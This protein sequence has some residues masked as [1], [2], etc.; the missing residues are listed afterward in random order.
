MLLDVALVHEL[1]LKVLVRLVD[2]LLNVLVRLVDALLM[3]S[4]GVASSGIHY[5]TISALQRAEASLLA[6]FY[7]TEILMGV[8]CGYVFFGDVPD[9][10]SV[11]GMAGVILVGLYLSRQGEAAAAAV[12]AP[13]KANTR[14]RNSA[15]V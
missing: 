10:W 12:P 13:P 3:A 6:P 14:T 9:G 8:V 5:L 2:E 1:L 4:L 15:L 7:Y 11:A